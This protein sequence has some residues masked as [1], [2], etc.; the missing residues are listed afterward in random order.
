MRIYLS[1]VAWFPSF[2]Y[3]FQEFHGNSSRFPQRKWPKLQIA[4]GRK[5]NDKINMDQAFP[6]TW[7]PVVYFHG[8]AISHRREL[9][10][11]VFEHS[12][13]V[14][15]FS[16]G[17]FSWQNKTQRGLQDYTS[18]RKWMAGTSPQKQVE[19]FI[20]IETQKPWNFHG[21]CIHTYRTPGTVRSNRATCYEFEPKT[22]QLFG[23]EKSSEHEFPSFFLGGYS[24]L[25]LQGCR[26]LFGPLFEEWGQKTQV[27]FVS[28]L[29]VKKGVKTHCHPTNN[30]WND[31]PA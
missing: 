23:S 10:D 5:G 13:L 25:I 24:M 27:L 2:P 14:T 20:L 8:S 22:P 28:F 1:L 29:G 30:H 15:S 3:A 12:K 7:S 16:V 18:P 26:C 17:G 9:Q 21:F 19:W 6:R 11:L 4:T 31:F